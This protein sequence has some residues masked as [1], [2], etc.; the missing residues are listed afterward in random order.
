MHQCEK[1]SN[2]SSVEVGLLAV[3]VLSLFSFSTQNPKP[4]QFNP[5]DIHFYL[6]I[7]A[8]PLSYSLF[9]SLAGFAYFHSQHHR[10]SS[11]CEFMWKCLCRLPLSLC[12]CSS[13]V[14]LFPSLLLPVPFFH[15]HYFTPF[16]LPALLSLFAPL[17]PN[18][19]S[20]F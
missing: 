8:I 4:I 14:P 5:P 17:S 19:L 12:S 7:Y 10:H 13:C 20:A 18:F 3:G 1:G 16:P 9:I 2:S 11:R 6:P 15:F